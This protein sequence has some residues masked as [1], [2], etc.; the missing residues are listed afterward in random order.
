MLRPEYT[1]GDKFQSPTVDWAS[2]V[3]E[4]A[5][6]AVVTANRSQRPACL[7]FDRRSLRGN[8]KPSRIESN[9]TAY[10]MSLQVRQQR[11]DAEWVGRVISRIGQKAGV[12]VRPA[13]GKGEPKYASAH[14]LR[15]SCGE[16][17]ATAGVPERE[18]AKVLRHADI[19]T[20]RRF[21][22]PGMVQ[23]S[24][25]IIR[26]KLTVPRNSETIEST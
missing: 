9:S 24:A 16:R 7:L 10:L 4:E 23:E 6:T 12:I 22:A 2:R 19:A 26:E 25:G 15:R 11:P 8:C 1:H 5:R 3:A 13:K 21:Y 20:T 18:I 14:D 17:M